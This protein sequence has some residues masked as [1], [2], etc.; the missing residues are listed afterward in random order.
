MTTLM[1][2]NVGDLVLDAYDVMGSTAIAC[3]DS[4]R[5]C[6][7]CIDEDAYDTIRLLDVCAHVHAT[8]I[9]KGTG[10]IIPPTDTVVKECGG[11]D[12]GVQVVADVPVA[13]PP[14]KYQGV[15]S[16][17]EL[18]YDLVNNRDFADE[19]C[20]LYQTVVGYRGPGHL[21]VGPSGIAGCSGEGVFWSGPGS[22]EKEDTIGYLWGS[23]VTIGS[24]EYEAASAMGRLVR[25]HG[26]CD[27]DDLPL[28]IV[29]STGSVVSY[30]NLPPDGTEP[31]CQLLEDYREML[32]AKSFP[33]V[34]LT[35]I[36][37]GTSPPSSGIIFTSNIV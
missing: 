19:E 28:F 26:F 4:H 22:L 20:L 32:G 8:R 24:D 3:L 10:A 14:M 35:T 37:E 17:T 11:D 5:Q 1:I 18:D 27:Q 2:V 21:T 15:L 30:I 36:E 16:M 23:F 12:D 13:I 9:S 34:A 25:S 7:S 6:I 29:A 31:N 33:V